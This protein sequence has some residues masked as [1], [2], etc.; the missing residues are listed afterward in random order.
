MKDLY[1]HLNSLD[2]DEEEL[3]VSE[4]EKA[5]VK[6]GIKNSLKKR[7]P[8][9]W[10]KHTKAAMLIGASTVVLGFSFPTAASQIPLVGDIFQYLD[11]GHT[12]FYN[13]YKEYST[14][15][16]LFEESS[17]IKVMIN[18][19]IFDGETVSVTFSVESEKDLGDDPIIF[20]HLDI[21][22]S[23]AMSGSSEIRKTGDGQYVGLM[24]ASALEGINGDSVMVKWD[25]DS[26][27]VL[28][29]EKEEEIEGDWKFGF[30]LKATENK[31][32]LVNQSINGKD[33]QVKID[34]VAYTPLS[35]IIYYEQ[36]A[37]KRVQ[38]QWEDAYVDLEVKDDLGNVY[39]GIGN[40][41]SGPD[42]Y[43]MKWSK[44]FEN[45]DPR[46]SKLIVTPKVM[47][48]S[49]DNMSGIEYTKEGSKEVV[50]PEKSGK[51]RE[52][53]ELD[54]VVIQVR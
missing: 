42:Q 7:K 40:G 28:Q 46:A 8:M 47:L 35:F 10:S 3:E 26:I 14:E 30:S 44:T 12:G 17:G 21:K 15:L 37:S 25:I 32:R 45:L 23:T 29:G 41:G 48:S 1:S 6:A 11:K 43:H 36:S 49:S 5:R 2:L 39:T 9:R 19:A 18:D 27:T 22:G 24:T 20:N 52:E 54:D 16:N 13:H 31:S 34:R 51:G 38:E 53:F 50:L 4:I 33:V